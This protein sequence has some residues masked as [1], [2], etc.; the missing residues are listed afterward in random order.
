MDKS[1][2]NKWLDS[3]MQSRDILLWGSADIRAL[4]FCIGEDHEPY[5]GAISWAIPMSPDIMAGLKNGPTQAYAN[6]Y[7]NVNIHITEIASS[8]SKA[9]AQKKISGIPPGCLRQD[10]PGKYQGGFSPQN[11]GH[12]FRSGLGG[13]SLSAGNPSIRTLGTSGNGFYG[14]APGVWNA[15]QSRVLRHLPRLCRCLS[16]GCVNR[17]VLEARH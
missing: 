9:I 14:Y 11:S 10:G 13:P 2:N 12:S 3:W 7:A 6:A 5:P 16:C 4:C 15:F 17:Q 1:F 8:L